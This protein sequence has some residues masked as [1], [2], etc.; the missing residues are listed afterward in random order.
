MLKVKSGELWCPKFPDIRLLSCPTPPT[1]QVLMDALHEKVQSTTTGIRS[2]AA[3]PDQKWLLAV[4]STVWPEHQIFA[5]DYQPV[6]V[7]LAAQ[8]LEN[9]DG[10]YTDLPVPKDKCKTSRIFNSSSKVKPMQLKLVNF[11]GDADEKRRAEKKIR[12]AVKKYYSPVKSSQRTEGPPAVGLQ[13]EEQAPTNL[14]QL[15]DEEELLD[16][17]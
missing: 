10:F 12:K 3:E 6:E 1:K 2:Q 15:Y 4:L 7:V 16:P 8:H 9:E 14:M 11:P 17:E 13:I 5:K